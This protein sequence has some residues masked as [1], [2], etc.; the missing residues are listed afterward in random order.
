MALL[1][2]YSLGLWIP[3]LLAALAAGEA[4]KMARKAGKYIVWIERIAGAL[5]IAIGII[6]VTDNMTKITVF[7]LKLFPNMPVF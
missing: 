3:F 6:L 4:M 1:L 2:V 7:F 5:L